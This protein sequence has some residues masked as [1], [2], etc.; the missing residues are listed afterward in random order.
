MSINYRQSDIFGD[1]IIPTTNYDEQQIIRDIL[2]LHGDGNYIDCDP[3]FSKG[4]FYKKGLPKPKYIFDLHPQT[5]DTIQASANK[6]P[7]KKESI[8]IIMFDPPFVIGGKPKETNKVNSNIIAHRFGIFQSWNELEIM[9]KNSLIEF[10]R[11]LK[12]KGIVIF[13]NQ[14]TVSSGRNYFTHCWLWNICTELGLI[15]IDLFILVK[16]NVLL[17]KTYKQRHARKYHSYFWVFKK[18]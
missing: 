12:P 5:K 15:P 17:G 2:Y 3:T 1:R 6:L 18:Q 11:I 9:Y 7:L 4:N 16:T 8:N 10:Y 14:D 13:K